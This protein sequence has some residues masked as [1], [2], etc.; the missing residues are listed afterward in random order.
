[1]IANGEQR[2]V[3]SDTTGDRKADA[4]AAAMLG[5]GIAYGWP[6]DIGEEEALA[7]LLAL[8][9]ERAGRR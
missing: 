3:R 1:M 4:Y 2:A 7:R 8:N 5:R 9:R 6:A